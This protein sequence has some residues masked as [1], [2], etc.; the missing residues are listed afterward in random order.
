M[1]L[2]PYLAAAQAGSH[3]A[4]TEA[5]QAAVLRAGRVEL[6]TLAACRLLAAQLT[7]KN[8]GLI[9]TGTTC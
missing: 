3:F 2:R 5:L 1:K 9:Q 6:G 4:A 7:A 8:D